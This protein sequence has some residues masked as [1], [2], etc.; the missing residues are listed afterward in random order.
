M[1]NIQIFQKFFST[2][3]INMQPQNALRKWKPINN[4]AIVNTGSG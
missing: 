2:D 3:F 4:F 1:E